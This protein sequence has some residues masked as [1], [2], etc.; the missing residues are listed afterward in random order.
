M[1]VP[2]APGAAFE[3][4]TPQP[5][6]ETRV[7]FVGSPYRLNYDAT[8][9]GQKFLVNTVAGSAPVSSITVIINA[10]TGLNPSR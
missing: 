6:F 2:I 4:G 9:D 5:L 1:A 8:G 7:P 10:L 3:V